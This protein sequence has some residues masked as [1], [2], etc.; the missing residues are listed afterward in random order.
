MS[1]TYSAILFNFVF[2]FILSVSAVSQ[3]T[4]FT[5]FKTQ[6][7]PFKDNVVKSNILPVLMGQIP[8][9]GELRF[10]YERMLSHNQ[11]V[12]LGVSYNFPNLLGFVL[13][14]IANPKGA[15]L[16]QYSLRGGRGT[17]GYRFYPLKRR[18][19]PEGLFLGPYGSYNFVKIKERRGNGSYEIWNYA[20][21]GLI[22]GY[23][24]HLSKGVFMEFFG[25]LGYRK[26]FVVYYDARYD[27]TSKTDLV[28]IENNPFKNVKVFLQM[29]IGFGF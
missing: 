14:A 27:R 2:A 23:Q 19:A 29:N 21:A 12:T 25:G 8:I 6:K 15:V 13:P 18:L 26:N 11:S 28:L 10:T 24:I 16:S 5:G 1:K 9:C 3:D 22:V 7:P 20:N 4:T 17:L